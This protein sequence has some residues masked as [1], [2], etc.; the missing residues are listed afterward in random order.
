M[1]VLMIMSWTFFSGETT[2]CLL[3]FLI[4]SH[5]FFVSSLSQTKGN[6]RFSRFILMY[7]M[8]VNGMIN[9]WLENGTGIG[10]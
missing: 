4:K 2:I 6:L 8:V 10:V 5:S 1:L 3:V 7:L 9:V